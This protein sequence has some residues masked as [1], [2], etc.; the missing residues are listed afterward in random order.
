MGS[1]ATKIV[2]I[3]VAAVQVGIRDVTSW[4]GVGIVIVSVSA[5]G[6][7]SANE[8]LLRSGAGE[9]TPLQDA[10]N[11]KRQRRT[12]RERDEDDEAHLNLLLMP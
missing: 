11:I 12:T 7:L 8:H 2:L 10:P 6:Y 9:K 3:V 5:F 1:N 4:L